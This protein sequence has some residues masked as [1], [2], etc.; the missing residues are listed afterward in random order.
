MAH[1]IRGP[2]LHFDY[3]NLPKTITFAQFETVCENISIELGPGYLC[4]PEEISEGGILFKKYPGRKNKFEYKTCRVYF[5]DYPFIKPGMNRDTKM[6]IANPS[7]NRL[8]TFLKA[9]HG[10]P[11]FTMD[12]LYIITDELSQVFMSQDLIKPYEIPRIVF[13]RQYRCHKDK[14]LKKLYETN[15]RC[16]LAFNEF[17]DTLK[18]C[19]RKWAINRIARNYITDRYL[20]KIY[21]KRLQE[22][23]V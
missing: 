21:T 9:F 10:A 16:N 23:L 5:M 11:R 1:H 6:W 8:G 3:K 2:S 18:R 20:L 13:P 19:Q 14:S 7:L 12:E 4:V 17:N 22:I 15:E